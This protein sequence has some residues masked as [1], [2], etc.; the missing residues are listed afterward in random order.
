MPADLK[1]RS[2]SGAELNSSF[3]IEVTAA[4]FDVVI[5]SRS[6]LLFGTRIMRS[7][8]S[9]CSVVPQISAHFSRVGG[10]RAAKHGNSAS[11]QPR[12]CCVLLSFPTLS[13]LLRW[14]T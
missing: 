1:A 9:F 14:T 4:G 10:W 7:S 5:E 3:S 6:A 12:G 8:S 13:G 11:L 2:P